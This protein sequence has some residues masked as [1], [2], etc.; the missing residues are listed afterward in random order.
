[1][2]ARRQYDL[3][4]GLLRREV[5]VEPSPELTAV[6]TAPRP[7]RIRTPRPRSAP[8]DEGQALNG[9]RRRGAT[10]ERQRY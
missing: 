8:P 7:E 10:A 5:G 1:V 4:R 3:F 2:A 6:A 9:V